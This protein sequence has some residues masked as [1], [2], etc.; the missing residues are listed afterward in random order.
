V[1][2]RHGKNPS[3]R[4]ALG[5]HLEARARLGK[6]RQQLPEAHLNAQQRRAFVCVLDRGAGVAVGAAVGAGV[7]A[8]VECEVVGD[9]ARDGG[10]GGDGAGGDDARHLVELALQGG[11]GVGIGARR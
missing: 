3:I 2:G 1:F 11:V 9:T 7:G 10:G 6:R 4:Q 8:G 5:T